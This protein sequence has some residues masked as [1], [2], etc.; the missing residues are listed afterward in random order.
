MMRI[1]TLMT[2]AMIFLTLQS[3][4]Q[5]FPW[6]AFFG[7]EGAEFAYDIKQTADSGY[8]VAANVSDGG[9]SSDENGP[10][11]SHRISMVM[12]VTGDIKT[13]TFSRNFPTFTGNP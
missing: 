11:R 13:L 12:F 4:G 8:I 7:N 9:S 3:E 5:S 1:S 10:A 6:S 2:V